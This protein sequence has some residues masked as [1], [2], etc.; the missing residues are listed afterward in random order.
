[1]MQKQLKMHE[2][3]TNNTAFKQRELQPYVIK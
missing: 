1:M 3:S 2:Q